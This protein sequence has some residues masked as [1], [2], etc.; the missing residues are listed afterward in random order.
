M[1]NHSR[2][3]AV[4]TRYSVDRNKPAAQS[5]AG[6]VSSMSVVDERLEKQHVD[7]MHW[8]VQSDRTAC[9]PFPNPRQ[10]RHVKSTPKWPCQIA[11]RTPKL[12]HSVKYINDFLSLSTTQWPQYKENQK[13]KDHY[14]SSMFES[15]S[16]IQVI[17]LRR[18]ILHR[19]C[20]GGPGGGM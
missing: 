16:L 18:H 13:K 19:P 7:L 4:S 8:L 5:R 17:F 15:I 6:A 1:H 20:Q 12:H 9:E 2:E 10:G 3:H 14:S 11:R